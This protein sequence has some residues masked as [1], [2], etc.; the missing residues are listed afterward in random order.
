MRVPAARVPFAS[1]MIGA[2]APDRLRARASSAATCPSVPPASAAGAL[3]GASVLCCWSHCSTTASSAAPGSGAAAG[4]AVDSNPDLSVL[5]ALSAAACWSLPPL[6]TA[7]CACRATAT[8]EASGENSA[9][10]RSAGS[11]AAPSC[12]A[13]AGTT[14]TADRVGAP[15]VVD[16]PVAVSAPLVSAS[17]ACENGA[18]AATLNVNGRSAGAVSVSAAGRPPWIALPAGGVAP[19]APVVC[20]IIAASSA[21]SPTRQVRAAVAFPGS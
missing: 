13:A 8:G 18:A 21:G 15:V 17:S 7:L 10:S 9:S 20:V 1:V 3:L 2:V 4:A 14:G 19:T 12:G 6:V 5:T 16:F 11:A